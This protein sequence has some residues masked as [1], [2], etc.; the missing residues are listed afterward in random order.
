MTAL[1]YGMIGCGMMGQEHIKNI[2]LLENTRIAAIFEPDSGMATVAKKL[3]PEA[4][5]EPSIKALLGRKDLDCLVIVSPNFLHAQQLKLIASINPLPILVEKPL[6][7]NPSDATLIQELSKNYPKPI[8]V[9]MEYRYMPPVAK[10]I[11]QANAL[12]GGVKLLTIKEHRFPFLEKV[13]DWNRFNENSG[14][15]FVEKCCHFFDLMRLIMKSEPVRI[16]ASAGQANNHLEEKYNGRTPDIW[17]NGYVIVDFASGSRAMLELC[18]FAEGSNYQEEI[19]AVGTECKV[20]CFV[21]G[22]SRFWPAHLGPSP[23]PKVIVSPRAPKGPQV[24]DI[25]VDTKLLQ[26]GDHNGSTYYQHQKFQQV[27]L[28]NQKPEVTLKDGLIAVQM[29]MAA[30][31]AASQSRIIELSTSKKTK[32]Q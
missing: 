28:G 31:E 20:E 30:Q 19:S 25:P 16:M 13:N 17:D 32:D 27:V 22:P 8:W 26:A 1:N 4:E 10:L 7:T 11:S 2:K 15:T 24:L 29:G 18:M 9:A 23:T 5:F 3:A 6:I 14:G 12:S 21:P